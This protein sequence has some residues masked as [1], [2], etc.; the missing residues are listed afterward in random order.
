MTS[1]PR[2]YRRVS[3]AGSPLTGQDQCFMLAHHHKNLV[4]SWKHA[5]NRGCTMDQRNSRHSQDGQDAPRPKR[6]RTDQQSN[7]DTGDRSFTPDVLDKT[8]IAV[9]LLE[10]LKKEDE[11]AAEEKDHG[12]PA[13]APPI[14][15]D[16]NLEFAGGRKE[17]RK[18]V[19]KPHP[20]SHRKRQRP[21]EARID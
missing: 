3:Q 19:L 12:R 4:A 1:T 20:S 2:R 10:I 8:V 15:I 6:S 13:Q 7:S 5:Q 17:A 16:L 9:P 21:D 18:E 11:T 14:I